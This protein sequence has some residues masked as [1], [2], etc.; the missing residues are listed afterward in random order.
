MGD[1]HSWWL[2]WRPWWPLWFRA[3]F[4]LVVGGAFLAGAVGLW[5]IVT[6]RTPY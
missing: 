5:L 4:L 2:P 1:R 6:G 3:Y